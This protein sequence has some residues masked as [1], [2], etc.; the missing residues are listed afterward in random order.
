MACVVQN[1][2]CILQDLD[3]A[4]T[5]LGHG[6]SG[7][8]QRCMRLASHN[9]S[10][11]Q[12]PLL[13]ICSSALVFLATAIADQNLIEK[14]IRCQNEFGLHSFPL[15]MPNPDDLT[16]S[17]TPPLNRK[18][19]VLPPHCMA[20]C[21]VHL[22]VEYHSAIPATTPDSP[23]LW[24]AVGMLLQEKP[25]LLQG[26][27]GLAHAMQYLQDCLAGGG[28]PFNQRRVLSTPRYRDF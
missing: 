12:L 5:W 1:E 18:A 16:H 26:K 11:T 9:S 13:L 10:S 15:V 21:G 27:P 19:T 2:P 17:E 24:V 20:L 8:V 23:L 22:P 28:R 3:M 4:W 6:L 14:P 25:A 7:P